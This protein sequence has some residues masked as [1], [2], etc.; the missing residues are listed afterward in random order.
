M[1]GI[2]PATDGLRNRCSTTE[3]HWRN[4]LKN[5]HIRLLFKEQ[6]LSQV[7]PECQNFKR[8]SFADKTA[9]DKRKV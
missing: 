8:G 6:C 9:T 1:A 7:T 4:S 3:L 2:E 5:K